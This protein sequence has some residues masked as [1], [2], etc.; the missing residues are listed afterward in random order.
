MAQA[1]KVLFILTSKSRPKSKWTRRSAVLRE[2]AILQ[3]RGHDALHKGTRT[4]VNLTTGRF[5]LLFFRVPA[6]TT[7]IEQAMPQTP[8]VVAK[9][10][11]SDPPE[12]RSR[13]RY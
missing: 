11:M 6:V 3:R 9:M 4:A 7:K 13:L 1:S 2:N 5:Q 12:H 10:V 8:S